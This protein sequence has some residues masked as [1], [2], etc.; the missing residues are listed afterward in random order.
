MLETSG[1]VNKY[2]NPLFLYDILYPKDFLAKPSDASMNEV[3]FQSSTEEYF[4][5][6]VEDNPDSLALV[7]WYVRQSPGADLNLLERKT[8]KIGYAALLSPDKLTYYIQAPNKP[9]QIFLINYNIGNLT[10]INFLTTLQ[11]MVNSFRQTSPA[12]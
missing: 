4:S 9:D 7:D 6:S 11:M 1:L 3:I 10:E 5:V 12:I 2:S 8:L